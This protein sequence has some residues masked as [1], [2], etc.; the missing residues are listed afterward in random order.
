MKDVAGKVA[1]I[2]GGAN[3]IGL[4]MARAFAGAGMKVAVADIDEAAAVSAAQSLG[5]E[6]P[7]AQAMAVKLD[8]SDLGGWEKAAQAVEAKLGPVRMLCNNAGVASAQSVLQ[9]T[10]MEQISEKEWRW[11]MSI[12]LSGAFYGVKTFLPRF[13]A[14]RDPCHIVHTASMAG[15]VPQAASI[16]GAYTVSKYGS[17]GLAEQLRLELAPFPHIGLSVLCP[18]IVQT[19]IQAHTLKHAPY[20][21]DLDLEKGIDNPYAGTQMRAMSADKVGAFVLEGVRSGRYY[22]LTHP[23]YHP[24]V[25][26]YH[27]AIME[28]FGPSAE[29]GYVDPV[30]P[31]IPLRG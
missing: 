25:A 31:W 30:P 12:N 28:G 16:P 11:M 19:Q 5:A 26:K 10:P 14:T 20:A 2:T 3:G 17:V 23:E 18:G 6:S 22:I 29:P 8:V 7:G 27:A 4:G 1:F 13:K 24:L 15:L 21:K 9:D